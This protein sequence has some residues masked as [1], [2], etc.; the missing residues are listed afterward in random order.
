VIYH[1]QPP[2]IPVDDVLGLAR[3]G[4]IFTRIQEGTQPDGLTQPGQTELDIPYRVPS[5]R[6]LAGGELGG[7]N[8]LAAWERAAV[9][10]GESCSLLSAVL[11]C[12]FPLSVSLLLLFP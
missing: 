11:F 12:V 2:V 9:T 7:G 8:S 10:G 4:L 6:V 5:C 3:T 1:A